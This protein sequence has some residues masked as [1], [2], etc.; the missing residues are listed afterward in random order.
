MTYGPLFVRSEISHDLPV[1]PETRIR[2][3]GT[4]RERASTG[5]P[6]GVHHS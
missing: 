5:E 3:F 1:E 6:A 4:E 2:I